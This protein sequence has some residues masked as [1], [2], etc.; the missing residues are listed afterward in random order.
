MKAESKVPATP[1]SSFPEEARLFCWQVRLP[2]SGWCGADADDRWSEHKA[3]VLALM[4]HSLYPCR[5]VEA[6]PFTRRLLYGP[7]QGKLR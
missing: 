7:V 6:E 2:S 3:S 5:L 4:K 1:I